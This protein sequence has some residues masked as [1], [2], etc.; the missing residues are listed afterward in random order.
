MLG[1][2][3]IQ[4]GGVSRWWWLGLAGV[5]AVSLVVPSGG[6]GI[7]LLGVWLWPVLLWSKLGTHAV[8]YGVAALTG[9]GSSLRLR[10]A[11]ES[12]VG[13]II[14]TL[15]GSGPLLRMLTAADGAGVAAWLV[16]VAFIPS[17]ALFLGSIGRSERVFQAVYL[18]LWYAVLN[19]V[20]AADFMG[21]RRG[22]GADV[23]PSPVIDLVVAVML[24]AGALLVQETRHAR[25]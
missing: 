7:V 14:T 8:E 1:E 11:A 23:G 20:T 3:R 19:G 18:V 22:S 4:L 9:S 2:L 25:R 21:A 15:A 13:A 16:A 6:T 24:T 12:S 5:T 10:L 17:L